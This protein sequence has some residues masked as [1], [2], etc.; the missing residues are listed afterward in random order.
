LSYKIYV[1]S[2]LSHGS[3]NKEI[4]SLWLL[5]AS[6]LWFPLCLGVSSVAGGSID[7][8]AVVSLPLFGCGSAALCLRALVVQK[9]FS[10]LRIVGEE[11]EVE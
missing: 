7:V 3:G 5:S 4:E 1:L 9:I 2:H 6:S 10:K 11:D 8:T